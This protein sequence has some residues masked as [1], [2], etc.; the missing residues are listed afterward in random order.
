MAA[1][2]LN[3]HER[4]VLA[5]AEY[6]T[7]VALLGFQRGRPYAYSEHKTRPEAVKKAATL[8]TSIRGALVYAVYRTHQALTDTIAA[9]MGPAAEPPEQENDDMAK[10]KKKAAA[11]EAPAVPKGNPARD[12]MEAARN[13]GVSEAATA[14]P[15]A[16]P[17]PTP[18]APRPMKEEGIVYQTKIRVLRR[19]DITIKELLAELRAAGF[20]TPSENTVAAFAH[21]FRHSLRLLRAQG[22]DVP[23]SRLGAPPGPRGGGSRGPRAVE[24][25]ATQAPPR[26]TGEQP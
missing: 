2:P 4:W 5:H 18:K 16:T 17:A 21:D 11:A 26:R 13:E 20:A 19:P 15:P 24:G 12:G 9:S 10:A 23:G 3:P 14:T 8:A 6:F 25:D 7:A 1:C 22:Y